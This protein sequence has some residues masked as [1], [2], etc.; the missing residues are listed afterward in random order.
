MRGPR[1]DWVFIVVAPLVLTCLV[2]LASLGRPG[3]VGFASLHHGQNVAWL[4]WAVLAPGV[5]AVAR[6]FRFASGSAMGWLA[7]HLAIGTGFS[8]IAAGL[9]LLVEGQAAFAATPLIARWSSGLL[10]Y[11]LIAVS[12]QALAYRFAMHARE[13]DAAKLRADLAEARLAAIESK[14]QPHFLFNALNS[15]AA[16]VRKDP[17]AAEDMVEQ[18]SEL[19]RAALQANPT[20]E[21]P[22]REAVQ[23]ADR[24]LTIERVRFRERLRSTVDVSPDASRCYVPQLMLQPLVENAVQHG[25]APLEEGG[26]ITIT[27]RVRDG[28]LLV[29]VQ[30]DGIG[31][32][33][34]RRASGSGVGLSAVQSALEQL[35]GSAQRF[36][37]APIEPRG[38]VASIEIPCRAGAS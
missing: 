26:S 3:V 4:V 33:N 22:L 6:R 28:R 27:A 23:L 35:Y 11:A 24:Y 10:I 9:T 32:G 37:I 25:I 29:D 20:R 36:V 12:Y 30:D 8:L 34:S 7:R 5:I 1:R 31:Y 14:L 2:T 17:A 19:L 18:L 21:V 13:A 16:L 15:V 38:T